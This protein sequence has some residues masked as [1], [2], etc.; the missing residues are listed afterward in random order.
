M[1]TTS[2]YHLTSREETVLLAESKTHCWESFSL[3][4]SLWLYSSNLYRY[5]G[6]SWL[7]Y[8]P[9]VMKMTLWAHNCIHSWGTRYKTGLWMLPSLY[10]PKK[11]PNA[12]SSSKLMSHNHWPN[13]HLCHWLGFPWDVNKKQDLSSLVPPISIQDLAEVQPMG[14]L[15]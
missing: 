12:V 1:L 9:R 4:K 8:E 15:G 7:P 13:P 10:Y 5:P 6:S 14:L 3:L 2:Q 11:L